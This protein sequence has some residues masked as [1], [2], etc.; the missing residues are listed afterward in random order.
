MARRSW[1][2]IRVHYVADMD[3]ISVEIKAF[4]RKEERDPLDENIFAEFRRISGMIRSRITREENILMKELEK[5]T[6]S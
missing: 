6:A 2:R 3:K 5:L 4:F 1:Q